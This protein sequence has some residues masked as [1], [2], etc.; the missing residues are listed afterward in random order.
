ML[1][2][3]IQHLGHKS[4]STKFTLCYYTVV[5][6]AHTQTHTQYLL[7]IVV[8][9]GNGNSEDGKQEWEGDM[10]LHVLLSF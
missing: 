2:N 8:V 10:L 7:E 6:K 9:S 1:S 4:Y 5:Q 3:N